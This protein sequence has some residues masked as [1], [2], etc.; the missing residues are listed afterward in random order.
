MYIK[1]KTYLSR[2]DRQGGWQ[3]VM[4][5]AFRVTVLVDKGFSLQVGHKDSTPMIKYLGFR[6]A[7]H[8]LQKFIKV[9]SVPLGVPARFIQKWQCLALLVILWEHRSTI[10][11]FHRVAALIWTDHALH[12]WRTCVRRNHVG[13]AASIQQSPIRHEH[14]V[15]I[16]TYFLKEFFKSSF[17]FTQNWEKGTEISH[18]PSALTKAQPP[19]L[20]VIIKQSNI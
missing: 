4:R 3:I 15:D 7:S 19:P 9:D 13:M 16:E 17:K 14:L 11:R 6:L 12:G 1:G 8:F 5:N 2:R 10:I 20:L 18:I